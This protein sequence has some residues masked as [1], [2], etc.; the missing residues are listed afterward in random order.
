MAW[1]IDTDG[2]TALPDFVPSCDM[3][4]IPTTV[5][6]SPKAA[7]SGYACSNFCNRY[8]R[9]CGQVFARAES[10]DSVSSE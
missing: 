8:L 3:S 9:D 10:S 5:S 2:N 4:V 1:P 6:S 7:A